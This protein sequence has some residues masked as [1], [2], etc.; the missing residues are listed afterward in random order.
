MRAKYYMTTLRQMKIQKSFVF[1]VILVILIVILMLNIYYRS[2][3]PTIKT[4]SEEH[5]KILALKSCTNAVKSTVKGV[6]YSDLIIIEKNSEGKITSLSANVEKMN[7]ISSDVILK[8][9]EELENLEES[10]IKV[11]I[12]TFLGIDILGAH[13]MQLRVKTLPSGVCLADFYSTF[14]NAG[15]NQ[16]RHKIILEISTQ[17]EVIAPFFTGVQ[18][19][20]NEIPIAETV[21]IGDIPSTYYEIDGITDMTKKEALEM[22]GN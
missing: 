3:K 9:H 11:P 13:G 14:D 12:G 17:V 15:I 18:E 16:T 20:K 8:T 22:I 21:I 1:F 19:Y 4:L 7:E 6:K 2:V 10:Y 5:A